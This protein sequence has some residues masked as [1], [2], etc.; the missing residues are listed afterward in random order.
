VTAN[1]QLQPPLE[2]RYRSK[3]GREGRRADRGR[4][5]QTRLLY[6]PESRSTTSTSIQP[7]LERR[8]RSKRGRE[9]RRADRERE[10]HE[11]GSLG[12][13]PERE[14]RWKRDLLAFRGGLFV[15]YK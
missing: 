2:P 6:C 8:Y 1:L 7:P 4:E 3:R 10:E 15:N 13:R 14:R 11:L 9:G 5:E 12:L